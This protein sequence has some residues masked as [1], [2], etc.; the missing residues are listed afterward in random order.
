M[1]YLEKWRHKQLKTRS[2]MA[3]LLLD[4]V[5]PLKK[6]FSP[7]HSW[8]K[9]GYTKAAYGEKAAL[10]EGFARPLWGLGPLWAQDNR[11]LPKELQQEILEWQLFY[12]EGVKNGTN[13]EHE[14]YWGDLLDFDQKMVEMASIASA[15]CLAPQVIWERLTPEE[16]KRFYHWF[17]Q[18]NEREVHPNNWRYFR[19]LVNTMWRVVGQEWDK[20][21]M[22]EDQ[23][24]IEDCYTEHGW[25]FDGTEH[26]IDYYIP[27]AIQFYSLLYS[28]F[29]EKEDSEYCTLL[30]QRAAEFS[31]E[32]IYWFDHDGNEIPFGRSLTYRFAHSAFFAAMGFA[33][34]EGAGYGTMRRLLLSNIRQ[35]MNR[36]IFDREGILTIGYG[37]PNLIISD[38]YNAP[39]SP[40]WCLK[41]FYALALPASHP[42]WTQPEEAYGY[43]PLKM[44]SAPH[45]LISHC[46]DG[47]VQA[48]VTGQ[49]GKC[50]GCSDAKYEKFVYSN[51]FGFSVGRGSSL[52]E[53]A[54]DSTLAVS[55]AE[56]DCYRMKRSLKDYHVTNQQIWMRYQMMPGVMIETT[57]I[58]NG[59]WHKR[60]HLIQTDRP[61]DIAEGG[62]AIPLEPENVVK[63][64][65]SGRFEGDGLRR[66][67]NRLFVE[68]D[69]GT[70]G[71]VAVTGGELEAVQVL[72]NTNVLYPL[73]IIPM[74]KRRLEPGT[75]TMITLIFGSPSSR[76]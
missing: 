30:K 47:H 48:F 69:W 23:A 38:R 41:A 1:G 18:I 11:E 6:Y 21:R 2:D 40:Y 13:P 43:A 46:A 56:D 68:F 34:N 50:F 35:W 76:S 52:A 4:L 31:W 29:M 75:H 45:M 67:G 54:F 3:E 58:P 28:R 64:R 62:F 37:Y 63:G 72:A 39:G 9:L 25:Y 27:F 36:P 74:V 51:Y 20:Q 12:L 7:G 60:V 14:E 55:L 70:S 44:L 49:K 32:F 17:N 57:L 53:G 66:E 71:I 8:L 33:E 5:R 15:V 16:Q 65:L 42:F 24:L 61:I 10:M 73:T 22:K 19:I 26:Q 59:P